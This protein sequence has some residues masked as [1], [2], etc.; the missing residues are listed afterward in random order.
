MMTR[1]VKTEIRNGREKWYAGF[2]L[3][4]VLVVVIMLSVLITG[5]FIS[6]N[7][8]H[9]IDKAKDSVRQQSIKEIKKGL[10]F[11][12]GD[13]K[14]FP[15]SNSPFTTA[16]NSGT[17]WKVGSTIYM[18]KVPLDPNGSPFIYSTDAKACPQWN[19]VFAKLENPSKLSNICALNNL[20][21]CVPESFNSSWACVISG[22]ID[23]SSVKSFSINLPVT[24]PT[25][26]PAITTTPL[27]TPQG[28]GSFTVAMNTDPYFTSGNINPYPAARGLQRLS[29]DARSTNPIQSVTVTVRTDTQI[30][31][32]PLSLTNGN[33]TNGT[34][35]GIW[36]ITDTI[37][38]KY[39]L[40]IQA[41]DN[42]G[43]TIT[44]EIPYK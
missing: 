40:Q 19:I 43:M 33:N 8:S 21:G 6:L 32:Y 26:I 28:S 37:N 44:T 34:W 41:T 3:I 20:S 17:E 22:K 4:E 35:Y 27:P 2:T 13:N 39:F 24:S 16:L 42:T 38:K 10:S 15:G 7:P 5:V 25:N 29:I 36:N 11:Y 18:K 31:T 14:C 1:G 12:Y 30:N 9:Q 23:C